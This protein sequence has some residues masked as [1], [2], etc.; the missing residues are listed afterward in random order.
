MLDISTVLIYK[1]LYT[2]LFIQRALFD[3]SLYE[4]LKWWHLCWRWFHSCLC[5]KLFQGSN[6]YLTTFP[7]LPSST[8]PTLHFYLSTG[9]FLPSHNIITCHCSIYLPTTAFSLPK[10]YLNSQNQLLAPKLHL[11][12]HT[13]LFT[14]RKIYTKLHSINDL[15][16]ITF[17]FTQL[18]IHL[19][20][21][22]TFIHT[23]TYSL[24]PKLH[25]NSHN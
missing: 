25:L 15:P 5:M 14:C 21:N 13:Y 22:Y 8:C 23:T 16:Q 2:F 7:C 6:E 20:K 3:R 19:P 11:Y 9:N 17:K 1:W 12:S 4:A 18:L 24:A 10:N